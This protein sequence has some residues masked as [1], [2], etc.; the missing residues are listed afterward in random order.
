[1]KKIFTLVLLFLFSLCLSSSGQQVK[2]P[3]LVV[4]IV[5]DQMR[6]DYLYRYYD[7]YSEK[8]GFRRLMNK[9]FSCENTFIPYV[10]S[11]TACGHASIYTGSV[12]A[13]NG[14]TGN[15][16][17]DNDSNQSV[18]CTE[19]STVY[20]VGSNSAAG[21]QS[22]RNLLVS[23]IGDE[24]R[25]A[26]NFR[27]KVVGIA[28]KDRGSILPAGH[29]ANAAFWYDN[30]SGDWI[31]SDYYMKSLPEWVNSF[32]KQKLTDAFYKEGWN[33]LYPL[34]TYTQSTADVNTYEGKPFGA[35]TGF[36]YKLE[37]Y[38]GKN[39]NA[40]LA[41]PFGNTLTKDFAKQAILLEKLGEDDI[42]DLLTVSF[43]SPDYIGHTFG[44]NSVEQEDNY[45][46]LDKDLGDLL[47]FLDDKIG[48]DEYLVFLSADH[49]VAHVPAFAQAH[50]LPAGVIDF[51]K[52]E[53]KMNELLRNKFGQ[54][55]L[56]VSMANYQVSLNLPVIASNSLNMAEIKKWIVDYLNHQ[57]GIERAI[58]LENLATVPLN[59]K[60][61]K[62]IE[63]GY[64]I[65]RSGQV[66]LI[67]KP[68]WIEGFG[69]TGT[70][71]GS[72]NPYDSHIPLLWYGWNIKPGTT[73]REVYMTD[74]APTL[75][76]ML[77]IQMPN[78][79][80]GNVIEEVVK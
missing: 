26:T 79:S 62:M 23:T 49:A 27:G 60:V 1:M 4:G 10:P 59:S 12:P 46:R 71:H 75:A 20:T 53:N 35:S 57:P 67:L 48:K 7:R 9:G 76:A 80:V 63:N 50:N 19:D 28:L 61:R 55:K 21:K 70:T 34:N 40:V 56:V 36:P 68:Q 78:G 16:W 24:L 11:V 22:P 8:G 25:L 30:S 42:T 52:L 65:H 18:Y 32:N 69:S 38:A 29:T 13:I 3:K 39:Y 33:T 2:R 77:H 64:N 15:I 44:P 14:I 74:I 45:L 6:W 41:T 54:D 43:S 72:W 47:D 5:V 73:N 31:T 51:A 58:D 37:Q 66:Q 17:W